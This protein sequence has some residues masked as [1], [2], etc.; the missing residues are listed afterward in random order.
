M[1]FFK[2]Y[3]RK[4]IDLA[5]IEEHYKLGNYQELYHF[6]QEA[7]KTGVIIPIKSSGSN[8]KKPA[9]YKTYRIQVTIENEATLVM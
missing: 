3:P 6:I 9:L 2:H 7:L 8:G 5:T 4:K 1:D